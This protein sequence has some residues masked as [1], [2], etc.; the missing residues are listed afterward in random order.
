MWV[1]IF[2][3]ACRVSFNETEKNVLCISFFVRI[4][5]VR[6]GAFGGGSFSLC[7]F[8]CVFLVMKAITKVTYCS[9]QN[10]LLCVNMGGYMAFGP[11]LGSDFY[12]P[13]I[14]KNTIN[15]SKS[16]SWLASPPKQ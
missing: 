5:S 11:I 13:V 3:A 4:R 2:Q 15:S 12:P 10:Q 7:V 8:V 9:N 6:E 14:E 1:G 16:G